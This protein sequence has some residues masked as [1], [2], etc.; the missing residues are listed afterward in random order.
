MEA[1]LTLIVPFYRNCAMLKRQV[2]EWNKYQMGGWHP[3][4]PPSLNVICIDDGSPEP[5]LPIIRRNLRPDFRGSDAVRLYRIDVDIPWNRGGARNLGAHLAG[6][7]WIVQVD[8]DHIFPA[9]AAIALSDFIKMRRGSKIQNDWYQFPRWRRGRADETRKKDRIAPDAEFGEI[10]P[11]VDSYLIRRD[12]YWKV[13]G[14][15]EDY[16]GAIGGGNPFLH[17]L[18]SIAGPPLMLPLPIRLEVYTRSEIADANEWTLSR[19]PIEYKRRKKE[20]ERRGDTA[21][22]NPLRFSWK[23]EL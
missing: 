20:K 2:E 22:K 10:H 5:A 12:L 21:P 9:D 13:G 19:D 7:D 11:H 14:Y 16:S 23:R 15:D 17:R 3:N 1:A 4:N 18:E 8:I 6:A